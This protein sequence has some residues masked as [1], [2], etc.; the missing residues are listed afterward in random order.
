M[1]AVA[2]RAIGRRRGVRR[3]GLLGLLFLTAVGPASGVE[4]ERASRMTTAAER[5][6]RAVEQEIVAGDFMATHW[7]VSFALLAESVE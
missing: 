6:V 2:P 4:P 1:I 7:L 5:Q 3:V